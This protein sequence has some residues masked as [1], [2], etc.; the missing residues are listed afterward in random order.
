MTHRERKI[1]EARHVHVTIWYAD[2]LVV[3][4]VLG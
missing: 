3:C 2:Q 4:G 1:Y